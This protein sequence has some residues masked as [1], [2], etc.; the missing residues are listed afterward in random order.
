MG[1][2]NLLAGHFAEAITFERRAVQLKPKAGTA[3]R[4]LAAAAGLAGDSSVAAEALVEA[5]R[6]Q[7]SLTI[8]WIE[9]Y[10]PIVQSK[11]RTRY[12]DGLRKAGLT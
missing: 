5:K 6:L 9:K 10:H 1:L 4:T 12:I 2:C 7:P 11:D 3:W 8:D